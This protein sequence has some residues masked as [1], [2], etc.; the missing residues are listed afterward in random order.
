MTPSV[1]VIRVKATVH[2]FLPE[3]DDL[4]FGPALYQRWRSWG[5]RRNKEETTPLIAPPL[6]KPDFD[7]RER[8]N[9]VL[10]RKSHSLVRQPQMLAKCF[11][12]NAVIVTLRQA[13]NSE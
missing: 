7:A 9:T 4:A 11:D 2:I 12:Y 8:Q 5:L 10:C 6:T 13:G 1:P 3:E